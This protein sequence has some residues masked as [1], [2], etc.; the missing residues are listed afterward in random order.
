MKA[1]AL[2]VTAQVDYVLAPTTGVAG[3]PAE[4]LAPDPADILSVATWTAAF[5]QTGQ[6]AAVVR[7]GFDERGLPVGLQVI[8]PR[9]DDLGVLRVAAAYEAAAEPGLP[10]PD[11]V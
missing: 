2:A 7:A 4:A 6:P 10:W 9:H 5:N 8:G 11:P 1:E 3:F